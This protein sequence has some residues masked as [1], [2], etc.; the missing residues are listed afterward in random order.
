MPIQIPGTSLPVKSGGPIPVPGS[1]APPIATPIW[2]I[3]NPYPATQTP[4]S[5]ALGTGGGY[6]TSIGAGAGGNTIGGGAAPP[7]ATVPQPMPTAQQ[8]TSGAIAAGQQAAGQLPGYTG[9]LSN[10]GANISAETAGQLPQDVVNQLAQSSAELGVGMGMPGSPASNASYLKALGLT[11]LDLTNQ[12]QQNFQNILPSLPGFTLSQNPNFYVTP[13]EE[14]QVGEYNQ[15][16]QQQLY[17]F[18]QT[19]EF[20][21]QQAEAERQFQEQQA[22]EG[23]QAAQAGLSAGGIP[24]ATKISG[25]PIPVG[26]SGIAPSG[27]GGA[28]SNPLATALQNLMNPNATSPISVTP[29]GST[30]GATPQS[31]LASI[32]AQYDPT[33]G[34]EGTAPDTS[35]PGLTP[36]LYPGYYPPSED[37]S[38]GPAAALNEL[39]FGDVADVLGG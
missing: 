7:I 11:S 24:T 23:L 8:S 1:Q 13:Q 19:E 32:L 29:I 3:N 15:G 35:A 30:L 20:Q 10:I 38:G 34:A 28:A 33:T 31:Q 17:E 39:G 21:A 14:T 9:D 22:Q 4:V 36:G 5:T 18:G 26:A 6:S 25:G 16:Q 27:G 37:T 2:G 12:G